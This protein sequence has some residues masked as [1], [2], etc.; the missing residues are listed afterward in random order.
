ME[1]VDK[2]NRHEIVVDEGMVA[3]VEVPSNL[4]QFFPDG[5]LLVIFFLDVVLVFLRPVFSVCE[6]PQAVVGHRVAQHPKFDSPVV[7]VLIGQIL[8]ETGF[9][10]G[11]YQAFVDTN[12][13]MRGVVM[14]EYPVCMVHQGLVPRTVIIV[15]FPRA[16]QSF[17][18]DEV[19]E[20]QQVGK[21]MLGKHFFKPWGGVGTES[22]PV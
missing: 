3:L 17:I 20:V 11:T 12:F 5:V 6:K 15:W 2:W 19:E 4:K 1:M 10:F 18:V 22:G 7:V 21:V 16:W 13:L 14:P 9:V 8:Y